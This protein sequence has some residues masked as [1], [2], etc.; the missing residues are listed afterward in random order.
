MEEFLELTQVNSGI[1]LW[2]IDQTKLFLDMYRKYRARVGSMQLRNLKALWKLIAE[3]MSSTL[4]IHLTEKHCENRWK[5][6]ERTY[7][8]FNENQNMTGRGRK[9]YEYAELLDEILGKKKNIHPTLI[10]DSQTIHSP[11]ILSSNTEKE[12]ENVEE[13]RR[14]EHVGEKQRR[15]NIKKRKTVLEKIRDDKLKYQNDR[16]EFLKKA[17]EEYMDV[18]RKKN[19]IAEEYNKL[20]SENNTV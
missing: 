11:A 17:H 19:Q 5:V 4:N 10:L 7:K 20:I 2:S 12:K 6:L 18:L 1:H 13:E 8:K 3:Q 9:V 14:K 16:L 15:V